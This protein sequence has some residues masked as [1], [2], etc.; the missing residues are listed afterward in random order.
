MIDFIF[1]CREHHIQFAESGH[2]HCAEGWIQVHCPFCGNGS[3]GWH[4]GFS[5]NYG[6]MNCWKCGKHTVWEWLQETLPAGMRSQVGGILRKYKTKD[7]KIKAKE[8]KVRLKNIK[9]VRGAGVLSTRHKRYLEKRDFDPDFLESF[10]KLKGTRHLS[11]EWNWR[12]VAPIQNQVRK[13]VA[14]TGRALSSDVKPRWR[15]TPDFEM[16]DEPRRLIYGIEKADINKGVLI[17]EGPSDVWRMGAGAV[18]LLGIDW[19]VEQAGILRQFKRRFILFDPQSIAQK[20]AKELAYWLSSLPG[21]TEILYD[22]KSDPGDLSQK[23]ANYIMKELG[24]K[25]KR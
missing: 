14:F 6:N 4:L 2:H 21:E 13:I 16:G 19:K 25:R 8:H 3:H 22:L 11:Q 20:R 7:H 24:L 10:W 1:L 18:G 17:V 12:I 15:T 23:E 5:L 9:S